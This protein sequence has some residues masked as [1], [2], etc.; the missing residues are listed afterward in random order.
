MSD[1]SGFPLE[2][3]LTNDFS[4]IPHQR[5]D[6]DEGVG[7]DRARGRENEE[8][9][10]CGGGRERCLNGYSIPC[11]L[12]HIIVC[13][14]DNHCLLMA[15]TIS[16]TASEYQSFDCD[17]CTSTYEYESFSTS[18]MERSVTR[19]RAERRSG[20]GMYSYSTVL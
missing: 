16:I 17:L 8:Q 13:S 14:S 2:R 4:E 19:I 5:E 1:N 20:P 12:S 6:Q 3:E 10:A 15:I 7:Q 9:E 18:G 11:Y